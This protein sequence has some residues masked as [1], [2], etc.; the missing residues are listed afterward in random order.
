ML[1]REYLRNGWPGSV[2]AYLQEEWRILV[3]MSS[4]GVNTELGQ[5]ASPSNKTSVF[6]RRGSSADYLMGFS[7]F[8]PHLAPSSP[9]LHNWFLGGSALFQ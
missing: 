2:G 1:I 8:V 9:L 5:G 6:E 4:F 7:G 3:K